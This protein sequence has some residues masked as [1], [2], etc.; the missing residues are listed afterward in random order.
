MAQRTQRLIEAARKQLPEGTFIVG[1]GLLIAG[2]TTYGFQIFSF[3]ALSKTDYT[4]L[5][6]L[7]VVVFVLAPGFFLPLEQEVG[8]ALSHRRALGEGGGPVVRRAATLGL[9]LALGLA[10]LTL[11]AAVATQFVERL[12][13]GVDLLV[14]C[15]VIALFTYAFQHLTRGTLSGNG[16]FAPYGIIIGAEGIIRLAP[17]IVLAAAGVDNPVYY[18]LCIAIPPLLASLVGLRGQHN[19]L[20]PGPDAPWSELSSKL[21]LLLGGS[22]A[23]Q[24]L[25]YSPFL[26][27]QILA[28]GA[29]RAAVADFIVGFFLARVPIVLFQAV[30]A[31][32]LPK[33]A[34]LAGAGRHDDFRTG[35]RKLVLIV[36]AIGGIGVVAGATLGPAVGEILFGSKFRLSGLDL[37]LLAGGSAMFI[38]ALTL[39]QALI[40]LMGHGKAL[41]AWIVGIIV[42]VAAT[43]ALVELELFL[44]VEI[45][46]IV[47]AAASAATMGAMLLKQL[48]IGVPEGSLET[49]V[50]QI[51]HEPL[52][53]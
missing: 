16:R 29:Q 42:F 11:I 49:L 47:G 4:A 26:A 27:A 45:A 34:G 18:G 38:I 41:V 52:E 24:L 53:I 32:L 9:G 15:L 50:D 13:H 46:F 37:A 35:L 43:G 6:G 31:A 19:L 20:T 33:L 17:C 5:N 40:A 14:P 28:T 30:Q 39:A 23:A 8:R 48:R 25:S 10:F 3:R 2:L 21:G 36:A 7:W 44:R 12:F 1:A 51:E 22:L